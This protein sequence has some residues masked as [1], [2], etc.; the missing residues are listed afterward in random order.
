M[1]IKE[2]LIWTV[3]P[4]GFDDKGALRVAIVMSPRLTPTAPNE[5]RLEG[6][7]DL[8][9]WP[10]VLG[11]MQFRL[12]LEGEPQ[13]F[14][15]SVR[16]QAESELWSR[17]FTKELWVD[18]FKF[19]DMSQH[20]LRSFPVRHLVRYLKD[21]YGDLART[22]GLKRPALFPFNSSPLGPMITAAAGGDLGRTNREKPQGVPPGIGHLLSEGPLDSEVFRR[23]FDK[24]SKHKPERVRGIDGK[25]VSDKKSRPIRALPADLP[26]D[27][28]AQF[29]NSPAAYAL[30]QANRFYSRPESKQDYRRHPDPTAMK[31]LIKTPEF[32]F[33]KLVA[34]FADAPSLMCRLG[35]VI[36]AS[37]AKSGLLLEK[38]KAAGPGGIQGTMR[39]EVIRR[40]TPPG[41]EDNTP[42]SAWQ[43]TKGRF[44]V[45]ARPGGDHRHG[46]LALAGAGEVL[47]SSDIGKMK[48]VEPSVFNLVQVDPDGSAIKLVN[49]ANSML[50]HL[51]S[52]PNLHSQHVAADP[53]KLTYTTNG[54][55]EST[56]ALRSAGLTLIRHDRATE[57]AQDLIA[58]SLKSDAL[59]S[60]TDARNVVLYAEDVLRGY[61]VDV[62]ENSRKKWLSLCRRIATYRFADNG[63]PLDEV[64]DEGYVRGA[65]TTTQATP[66]EVDH[67][68]GTQDHYLHE[69][70]FKWTGWS[71][72]APRPGKRI[73]PKN[74]HGLIQEETV[75]PHDDT[76]RASGAGRFL[77]KAVAHPGSLPR[78]RFSEAYRLRARLVDLAGNSLACDDPSLGPLEEASDE[79]VY[80]RLEPLDPPPLV[81]KQRVSEGES[82]EHVV[83]RS[84]VVEP[85]PGDYKS[86]S[87][88]D[89]LRQPP[90]DGNDPGVTGFDYTDVNLRHVVPPKTSQI[91]AEQHGMFE[92]AF[93]AAGSAGGPAAIKDAYETIVPLESGSLYHG[94]P[95]VHLITP[96]KDGVSTE[97]SLDPPP[98][99][100]FRLEPG[101]Y[102]IHTEELIKTPYLPDPLA[103]AVVL[104]GVPGIVAPVT[105]DDK[106]GVYAD[107]IPGTEELMLYVPFIGAEEAKKGTFPSLWPK[108]RGFRIAVKEAREEIDAAAFI[109][110]YD[111]VKSVPEWDRETR[112]LTIYLRKGEIAPVRYACAVNPAMV[113]HLALPEWTGSAAAAKR[114]AIL[115]LLGSHWMI[116]PDRTMTLVHAT[117]H[118]V[119]PPTFDNL[120]QE[121][122]EGATYADFARETMVRYHARSTSQLEVLAE[123][124]EW[125]DDEGSDKPVRRKV[126]A[127]LKEVQIRQPQ[128]GAPD[129]VKT[130]YAILGT[131]GTDGLRAHLRHEFGDNK[132]RFIRYRLQA[133]TRFREYLPPGI[134]GKEENLIRTGPV[135]QRHTLTLPTDYYKEDLDAA[136]SLECG[137]PLLNAGG[138]PQGHIV[139]ASSR[140]HPPK[141]AYQV[142]AQHW[143]TSDSGTIHTVVR[144]GNILRVYLDRPWFSSGEGEL[145]GVIVAAA[146]G[147]QNTLADLSTNPDLEPYVS[148]WGRD[149]LFD[150][151][152]PKQAITAAAFPN[153]VCTMTTILPEVN[154]EVVVAGHRVYFDADRKQWFADLQIEAGESYMTFVRLGLVRL[155]PHALSG[156]ALS[157][158]V[159]PPFS[160]LLP[161]R[162]ILLQEMDNGM[163]YVKVYGPAPDIGSASG[164]AHFPGLPTAWQNI[165]GPGPGRNR[166]EIVVQ[167]KSTSL[168]TDLD[169]ID[170]KRV[171]KVDDDAVPHHADDTLIW[172]ADAIPPGLSPQKKSIAGYLEG[173]EI[174][175]FALNGHTRVDPDWI[176]RVVLAEDCIWSGRIMVPENVRSGQ[177]RLVLRE[178]ERYFSDDEV[179]V[180]PLGFKRPKVVERLVFA[181]EFFVL[182]YK[183]V[184]TGT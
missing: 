7:E 19:T 40:K 42:R 176:R 155:Q 56:P 37:I 72:V 157:T 6:Y 124:M 172:Q 36:D 64:K 168:D 11:S 139:M 100:G 57:L 113:D 61:R 48:K 151:A 106:D 41:V 20:N 16:K 164:Q 90:Y 94:G 4:H 182:G 81:L 119:C 101:Q 112:T 117:Q 58:N 171:A 122:P 91:M 62:Y 13:P 83:I 38:M 129:P 125:Q 127:R 165:L 145:L 76:E 107:F 136:T 53:G 149:P 14:E 85:S 134:T 29:G 84:D 131:P 178:Y 24:Y 162:R 153:A 23:Y 105:I 27:L 3:L 156:M 51:Q 73:V 66:E 35:L 147:K 2:K 181:R 123:W 103:A 163:F 161:R 75:E 158:V 31:K 77:S 102:V 1:A 148:Q 26:A 144:L 80:R 49:F 63:S 87:A 118:P 175:R 146:D 32:D 160:N 180:E 173:M 34:S 92:K 135:W 166:I 133:T 47:R 104:R 89:Y 150:S 174:N 179:T 116:T 33:H 120:S 60:S 39:L 43:L 111:P 169:W 137:A 12:H 17:L 109:D 70:L 82:L 71:L 8:L 141:V 46:L 67:N 183:P 96:A 143:A 167:T 52:V 95:S 22:D 138:Q 54:N 132:F 65:S 50:T 55:Q 21:H 170:D 15:L 78:L 18:E 110:T 45:Q 108:I 68:K 25:P 152:H 88:G 74:E 44:V 99:E 30:Y 10:K 128:V 177:T 154:R 121:R 126:S 9:D 97:K 142:P 5:E 98:E 115:A 93:D 184:A 69:A 86:V 28:A 159:L 59:D 130:D 79:V 140:P 114:A